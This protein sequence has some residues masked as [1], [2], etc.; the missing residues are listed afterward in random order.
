MVSFRVV[1]PKLCERT[2]VNKEGLWIT[3]CN[4]TVLKIMLFYSIIKQAPK[5]EN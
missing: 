2:A 1:P 3:N 4:H 5:E